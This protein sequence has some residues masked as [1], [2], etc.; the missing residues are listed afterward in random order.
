MLFDHPRFI[1]SFPFSSRS[2]LPQ[3]Q[4]HALVERG[5]HHGQH[6]LVLVQAADGVEGEVADGLRKKGRL[7]F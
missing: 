6:D 1:S 4:R 2:H 3:Q 5:Q 7:V